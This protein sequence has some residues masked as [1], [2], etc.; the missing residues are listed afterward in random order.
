MSLLLKQRRVNPPRMESPEVNRQLI[1]TLTDASFEMN[2]LMEQNHA[3]LIAALTDPL[4]GVSAESCAKFKAHME[5]PGVAFALYSHLKD[6]D[7]REFDPEEIAKMPA[8][9]I[10]T[11]HKHFPL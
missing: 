8:N 4:L 1:A 3:R 10:E 6:K 2:P 5:K 9:V 7:L 11:L